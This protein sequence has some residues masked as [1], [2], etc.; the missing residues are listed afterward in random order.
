MLY[1][2]NYPPINHEDPKQTTCTLSNEDRGNLFSPSPNQ[3]QCHVRD[4]ASRRFLFPIHASARDSRHVTT[5]DLE[6]HE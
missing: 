5:Y 6:S 1:P 4:E 2:H 3:I